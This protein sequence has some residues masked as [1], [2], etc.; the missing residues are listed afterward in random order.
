MNKWMDG[1]FLFAMLLSLLFHFSIIS[2]NHTR[3][4]TKETSNEKSGLDLA[5]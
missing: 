4:A 1:D 3:I 5:P 2:F